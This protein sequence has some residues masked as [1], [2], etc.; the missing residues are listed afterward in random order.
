MWMSG[1]KLLKLLHTLVAIGDGEKVLDLL[2]FCH[3]FS[4]FK[5]LEFPFLSVGAACLGAFGTM[6]TLWTFFISLLLL[7]LILAQ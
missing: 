4:S 7:D 6:C 2:Y 3:L 1:V 5:E